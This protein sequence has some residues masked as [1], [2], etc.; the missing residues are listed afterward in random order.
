MNQDNVPRSWKA[1]PVYQEGNSYEEYKRDIQIWILLK[2]A[3]P[4]ESGLLVYRT[5]TGRAK[6]SCNDLTPDEIASEDGLNLIL[7]RLDTLFLGDDNLRI[8]RDLDVFE[9]FRRINGMSMTDFILEFE[10]LHNKIRSLHISGIY[11]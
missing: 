2:V 9:K 8:Y 1:P 10:N 11:Q 6:A 7:Q 5:L 3:T 4:E